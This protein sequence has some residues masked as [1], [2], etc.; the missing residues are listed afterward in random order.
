MVEVSTGLFL[1]GPKRTKKKRPPIAHVWDGTDTL[2]RMWSTG[3]M[4]RGGDWRITH[5]AEGRRIC[6]M[7][8][9]APGRRRGFEEALHADR[10]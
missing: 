5:T 3:G 7:C 6:T 1:L 10:P 4:Y 9:E 8:A 2:C